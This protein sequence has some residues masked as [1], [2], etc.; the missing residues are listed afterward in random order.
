MIKHYCDI[1]GCEL[2]DTTTFKLNIGQFYTE[3]KHYEIC[4]NCYLQI[5]KIIKHT[6][7]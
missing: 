7:N 4:T 1:C 5:K 2:T 6:N 3:M